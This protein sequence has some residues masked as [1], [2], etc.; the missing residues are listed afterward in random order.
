V[1]LNRGR[2]GAEKLGGFG[3]IQHWRVDPL[4]LH[5][6]CRGLEST[7]ASLRGRETRTDVVLAT[8]PRLPRWE[9]ALAAIRILQ[10][11]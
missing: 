1:L 6:P 7:P 9:E 5:F 4:R 11:G 3:H 10:Q 8:V 2:V